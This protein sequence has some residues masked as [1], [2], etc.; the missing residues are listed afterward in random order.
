MPG[1]IRAI[2]GAELLRF[3]DESQQATVVQRRMVFGKAAVYGELSDDL[4]GYRECFAQGC[5]AESLALTSQ[6]DLRVIFDNRTFVLGR[7]KAGTARF[8]DSARALHF[9]ADTP[10]TRWAKDLLTSMDRHDISEAGI[11]FFTHEFRWEY[12]ASQKIK[13]ITRAAL[14]YCSIVAFAVYRTES[15]VLGA[16]I[17]LLRLSDERMNCLQPSKVLDVR[18]T[19]R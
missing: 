5:F 9:E 13:V 10:E 2:A 14:Q 1:Q 12:R 6:D 8:Y 11:G 7:R 17:A 15:Q 3:G 16:Q 19:Q 18:N 4:G